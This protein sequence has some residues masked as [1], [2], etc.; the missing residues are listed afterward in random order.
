MTNPAVQQT[1]FTLGWR[2]PWNKRGCNFDFIRLRLSIKSPACLRV[3]L[4]FL[5]SPLD[6]YKQ[7]TSAGIWVKLAAHLYC[8]QWPRKLLSRWMEHAEH[9]PDITAPSCDLLLMWYAAIEP[10][11]FLHISNTLTHRLN[12]NAIGI[13]E[14]W[15]FS[16][17]RHITP[18]LL[19]ARRLDFKRLLLVCPT[20]RASSSESLVASYKSTRRYTQRT[21]IFVTILLKNLC[22]IFETCFYGQWPT[23]GGV[24]GVQ[25]P[26]PKFRR[27]SKIVP[28]STRLWKLLKI[29]EFR[30]P[31]PQDVRK[32]GSK[33]LKLPRFAIVLH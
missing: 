28:N 10:I 2:A 26:P 23:E 6:T 32:K 18:F 20:E 11:Y 16:N 22:R 8:W 7:I 14:T 25:P 4:C 1:A 15:N 27:P 5:L 17:L 3:F 31:T 33:I 12:W 29:A 24:W 9:L 21:A 30:M 19:T 13:F